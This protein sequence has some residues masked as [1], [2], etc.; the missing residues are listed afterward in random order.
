MTTLVTTLVTTRVTLLVTSHLTT[1]VTILVTILVNAREN[2]KRQARPERGGPLFRS[3][4]QRPNPPCSSLR[5][6]PKRPP[7]AKQQGSRGQGVV[8]GQSRQRHVGENE[9]GEEG[10]GGVS[11]APYPN[12]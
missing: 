4:P 8:S 9:K 2:A 11:S 3:P 7:A 12:P 5:C 10:P 6:S 1:C